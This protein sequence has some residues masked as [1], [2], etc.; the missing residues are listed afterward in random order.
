GLNG[1]KARQTA[2]M[3]REDGAAVE[4]SE[5][6]G[7]YILRVTYPD[8]LVSSGSGVVN[9]PPVQP[10][11]PPAPPVALGAGATPWQRLVAALQARQDLSYAQKVACLSQWIL[12]SARGTSELVTRHLNFGGLKYRARMAGFATPVDYQASDGEDSYCKFTSEDAFITGYWRFISSGPYDGWETFK[13]NSAGYIRH[14]APNYAGDIAY[15]TKVLSLFD[16]AQ[17][18]LGVPAG[19]ESLGDVA[20]GEIPS[21]GAAAS[22]SGA[23]L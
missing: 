17:T 20:G 21:G 5:D 18:L 12:E 2:T 8:A 22:P 14:I 6:D 11:G 15:V 16:E 23:Q 10:G 13:D 9:L 4:I 3:F 1:A 7:A 19:I